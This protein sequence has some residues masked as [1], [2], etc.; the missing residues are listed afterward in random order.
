MSLLEL[1]SL[2]PISFSLV[3]CRRGEVIQSNR[4]EGSAKSGAIRRTASSGF[5]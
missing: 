3:G 4:S 2:V 5:V 1:G